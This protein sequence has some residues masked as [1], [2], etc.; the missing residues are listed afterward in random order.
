MTPSEVE[1][2][3]SEI[4]LESMKPGSRG[5]DLYDIIEGRGRGFEPRA[6]KRYADR[7]REQL[8]EVARQ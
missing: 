2:A 3:L 5:D 6:A 8:A 1:E 4:A 7:F